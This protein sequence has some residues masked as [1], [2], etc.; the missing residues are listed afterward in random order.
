MFGSSIQSLPVRAFFALIGG[1]LTILLVQSFALAAVDPPLRRVVSLDGTW[2]IAEGS[3]SEVPTSFDHTVPVPGLVDMAEPAFIEPGPRQGHGVPVRDDPRREAFWYRRAFTLKGDIP[4][5]AKLNVAKAMFGTKVWI[6]G[7]LVGEHM[8]CFT[9]GWFDVHSMI[10]PGSN[11]ILVRIGAG[12]TCLDGRVVEG[13]DREKFHYIPG[14]FDSVKLVL[15][16]APTIENVQVAPDIAKRQATVRVYL[17]GGEKTTVEVEVHEAKSGKLVGRMTTQADATTKQLDLIV[18]IENCRLW[19]PEDPFLY[20]LVA[21]TGGDEFTTRFGM[22]E[23]GFDPTTRRAMLNGR[24]Y[25]MR[26]SNITLYRFFEDSE[27]GNLPWDETWVRQLFRKIKDMHWNCLR[28]CIGFP[29]E[30][31]YRIADEE[32]ILIDD[33]FPIW[34]GAPGWSNWPKNLTAEDVV[35]EYTEW[36]QERWNHPSVVIWDACNETQN[37]H[38]AD[39][40]AKVRDLDMSSRPW[41]Q[42]YTLP[43]RPGDMLEAHPYHFEHTTL[44]RLG[45]EDPRA[46]RGNAY[47]SN[48]D[49]YPIVINEYAWIWL[50]RDGTPTRLTDRIYK[51]ALGENATPQ[52]R[53]HMQALWLAADTEFWRGHRSPAALMHFTALGYSQPNGGATSDNWKQGGV[54]ALEWEPEFYRYVRDAFAPVGMMIDYWATRTQPGAGMQIPVVLINDLYQPWNGPVSLRIRSGDHVAFEAKQDARIEPLGTTTLS[55][56]ITW[57]SQYGD[58]VLEAE[59][60]GADGKPVRS[61]REVTLCDPPP[62]SLAMNCP[63]KASSVRSG[64]RAEHAVDDNENTYWSSAFQ[65]D[66]SLTVD[67][68]KP[69][70]VGQID[71][72][73]EAAYAKSFAVEVSADTEIWTEVYKTNAGEGDTTEIKFDPIQARYVRIV[74]TRRGTHWGNA[75]Y[76]LKVF[77]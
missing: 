63:V 76:E 17:G 8:P 27:R 49:K 26:G 14:I 36:M 72:V 28:F 1:A 22:R 33:E 30:F 5:V 45:K 40:V 55:F 23:F 25:F 51:R 62:V 24:P 18:P 20:E 73:W 29:P 52:Q 42:S 59:L 75:I 37:Q 77:P 6:N 46:V 43:G 38:V 64:H 56:D 31:W 61:V 34:Y 10:R 4:A 15:S 35:V 60:N 57:P 48:D 71:I 7:E 58:Y 44:S 21:R 70:K 50:N 66:A 67:L 3:M 54:A 32:G 41:D 65:D 9:S 13:S 74:C 2:Q 47:I 68:G 16:G 12:R 53:F 69:K 19:S 11:E 39:A